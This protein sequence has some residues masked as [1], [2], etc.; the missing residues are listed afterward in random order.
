[1][2]KLV[3]PPR[4]ILQPRDVLADGYE[5]ENPK[6]QA[7]LK[8]IE[9]LDDDDDLAFLDQAEEAPSQSLDSQSQSQA[10]SQPAAPLRPTAA[11]TAGRKTTAANDSQEMPP[12]PLPRRA[13]KYTKPTS[14]AD[15]RDTLSDLIGAPDSAFAMDDLDFSDHSISDAEDVE[16]QNDD[17]NAMD[18]DVEN[19]DAA[20]RTTNP[21]RTLPDASHTSVIDRIALKRM[22]SSTLSNANDRLA[23]HSASRGSES[24]FRVPS[25]L[26]RVTSASDAG[27][28]SGGI[29]VTGNSM[30]LGAVGKGGVR[31]GGSK[32][33]SVG[34]YGRG[35]E[36]KAK[37]ERIEKERMEERVRVGKMRREGPGLGS[38]MGGSWE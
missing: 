32:K 23:F 34:Y 35:D 15:I 33:S 9:D 13:N 12:P 26:R 25:L 38:F 19:N 22:A 16:T 6:Q 1:M 7:F 10:L 24:S 29:G 3:S 37:L 27:S 18:V 5:A 2:V 11:N 31:M 28:N 4:H 21:R 17:E 30:A 20:P 36:R 14:L 8:A